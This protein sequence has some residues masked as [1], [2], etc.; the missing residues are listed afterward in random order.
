M[1]VFLLSSIMTAG[2]VTSSSGNYYSVMT[3]NFLVAGN[4]ASKCEN[5]KSSLSRSC[6]GDNGFSICI[7]FPEI[8]ERYSKVE[9]CRIVPPIY[10]C[11]DSLK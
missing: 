9:V 5:I 7:G 11:D 3:S 6:L 8:Y 2:D 1:I 4:G 10:R